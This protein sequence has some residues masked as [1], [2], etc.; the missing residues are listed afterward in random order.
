MTVQ[1]F[2]DLHVWQD[3]RVLTRLVRSV[4]KREVVRRD[5]TWVDQVSS[6]GLSV[7]AN[8]AEGLEAGSDLEF[9]NFAT[10]ARRSAAEVRSHYYYGFDECYMSEQ[11]FNQV[12]EL[13]KKISASLRK[14][15]LHLRSSSQ[16]YRGAQE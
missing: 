6:A 15:I 14:L 13:T 5:F 9:A 16:K 8:I 1:T 11:E 2:E 3:A 10:F 12:K 4:C 7:M